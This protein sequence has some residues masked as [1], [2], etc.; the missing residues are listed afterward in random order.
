MSRKATYQSY[1][2]FIDS[3]P[4]IADKKPTKNFLRHTV[5]AKRIGISRER[6]E[7]F[8]ARNLIPIK[9]IRAV[10]VRGEKVK[11]VLYIDYN[12]VAYDLITTLDFEDRPHDFRLNKERLYKPI[13]DNGEDLDIPL[14]YTSH[15]PSREKVTPKDKLAQLKIEKL[16]LEIREKSEELVHVNDVEEVLSVLGIEI[17][18]NLLSFVQEIVSYF[19]DNRDSTHSE[20]KKEAIAI[21][22]NVTNPLRDKVL[23]G[24]SKR[25]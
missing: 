16:E 17:K 24:L 2:D 5:F 13:D 12:A 22:K 21:L 25:R 11:K 1:R 14:H 8:I 3:F 19:C 10:R 18:N 7:S 23:N 9:H 4:R 15:D 6:M 20:L